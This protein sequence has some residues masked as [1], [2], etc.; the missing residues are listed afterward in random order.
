MRFAVHRAGVDV[1]DPFDASYARTA[2]GQDSAAIE[3]MGN[4][5]FSGDAE[6]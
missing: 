1:V 2:H 4:R 5:E 3:A 6:C